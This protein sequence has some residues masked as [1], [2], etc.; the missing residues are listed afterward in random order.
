MMINDYQ[1]T[2]PRAQ[3]WVTGP[4]STA[5]HYRRKLDAVTGVDVCWRPFED[6][7][8]I[9]RFEQICLFS[10]YIRWGP[11]FH[12][13]MPERVLRQYG[14]VQT[15]PAPPRDYR[16]S[17]VTPQQMDERWMHFLSYLAQTG[18]VARYASQCAAGYIE[19]YYSI[20]H[21]FIIPPEDGGASRPPPVMMDPA[22]VAPSNARQE[23]APHAIV[24]VV[25]MNKLEIYFVIML[26]IL[27]F[28]C[29][30]VYVAG[31]LIS[32]T[33]LLVGGW[34]HATRMHTG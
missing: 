13:H 12:K 32:C 4:T 11:I 7:R 1:E 3:R 25:L 9:R 21:P 33:V 24:S 30:R 10:G 19:W 28:Y 16:A 17:P 2:S 6:H 14:Y 23:D 20:S 29:C 26:S 18:D 34:C 22:A 15:I 27:T 5:L 31:W 8:V